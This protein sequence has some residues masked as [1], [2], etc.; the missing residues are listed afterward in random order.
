MKVACVG[1]LGVM[2]FK[3]RCGSHV[4]NRSDLVGFSGFGLGLPWAAV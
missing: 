1:F 3:I 2:E 4:T